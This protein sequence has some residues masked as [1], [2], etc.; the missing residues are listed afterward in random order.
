M[1]KN[2]KQHKQELHAFLKSCSSARANFS[3]FV[4]QLEWNT[5]LRTEVDSMLIMY[6]QLVER[7]GKELKDE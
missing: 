3:K 2:N 1:S 4:L 6:D 7:L 5:D